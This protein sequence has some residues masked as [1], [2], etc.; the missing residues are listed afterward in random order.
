MDRRIDRITKVFV[1]KIDDVNL[2][3]EDVIIHKRK[4]KER[5]SN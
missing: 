3:F 1:P 5:V 4:E 2:V